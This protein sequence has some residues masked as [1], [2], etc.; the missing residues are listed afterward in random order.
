MYGD[1]FREVVLYPSVKAYSHC[2]VGARSES[3]EPTWAKAQVTEKNTIGLE[4]RLV[5][6]PAVILGNPGGPWPGLRRR[7][8]RNLLRDRLYLPLRRRRAL[9]AGLLSLLSLRHGRIMTGE[10]WIGLG[11]LNGMD[12]KRYSRQSQ[13]RFG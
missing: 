12:D 6:P 13:T 8:L 11:E 4:S 5:E 7:L 2:P 1:P 3:Y 9:L 10:V